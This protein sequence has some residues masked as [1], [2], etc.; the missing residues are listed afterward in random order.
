MDFSSLTEFAKSVVMEEA[1]APEPL[2][3]TIYDGLSYI[4]AFNKTY[5]IYEKE[6]KLYMIDQHAAHEKVLYES[7][8]RAF[9]R[10]EIQ[11]Q[12]LMLPEII[13]L[14][15]LEMSKYASLESVFT[16]MGFMVEVFGDDGVVVRE[17][18]GMFDIN[19]AR[20]M[21]KA[22]F[23]DAKVESM[24]HRIA[25]KACKAAIK[26]HDTIS[27]MEQDALIEALKGLE[28]PYTCPHGRPIIISFTLSE[29]E[30]KFK[31]VL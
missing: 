21:V 30:R 12:V 15:P 22:I 7:Y 25:E 19:T 3:G 23:E 29:I 16:E 20:E 11:S 27:D 8:M 10:Q 28:S 1:D 4:G 17:I 24:H 9:E 2:I 6:G 31:R 26:A 14:T 5:L 13:G 18:P